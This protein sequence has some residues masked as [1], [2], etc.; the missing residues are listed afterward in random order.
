[1]ADRSRTGLRVR[2]FLNSL[3]VVMGALLIGDALHKGVVTGELPATSP[4]VLL[5]AG[6]GVVLALVG[7]RLR[8]DREDIPG[9]PTVASRE[10][11]EE[12]WDEELSPLAG[13][14]IEGGEADAEGRKTDDG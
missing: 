6:A 7:Y 9:R 4:A 2:Y 10:E 1:M 13:A 12:E 11:D 8:L 3:F 5:E 14:D